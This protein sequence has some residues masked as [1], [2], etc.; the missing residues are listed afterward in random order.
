MMSGSVHG[1][2][3]STPPP[4]PPTWLSPVS[5]TDEAVSA[6]TSRVFKIEGYSETR[7]L[8]GAGNSIRFPTFFLGGHGWQIWYYPDGLHPSLSG[9]WIS[10]ALVLVGNGDS[11][12]RRSVRGSG[13]AE[14]G[15]PQQGQ[16]G[17]A[18]GAGRATLGKD[19]PLGVPEFVER[20]RLQNSCYLKGDCVSVRCDISVATTNVVARG[21]ELSELSE[22]WSSFVVV[23]PSDLRRDL[24]RLLSSGAGADVALEVRG[25]TIAAHWHILAAR[26]S[27]FAAEL[28]DGT[29]EEE[30][31]IPSSRVRIDAM[32][33]TA[34]K[35]MLHFIYTDSLPA[36]MDEAGGSIMPMAPDLLVAADRYDLWGL[37]SMCEEKLCD[38]IAVD[39]PVLG[40]EGFERL[41]ESCPSV[42]KDHLAVFAP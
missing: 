33:A 37:K 20:A 29:T 4:S 17:F 30:K 13:Q 2:D 21:T 31:T 14:T 36:T 12:P 38:H 23:P 11:R 1:N 40:T 9:R 32:D 8:L 41:V 25:E 16:G 7:G 34:F 22:P 19:E 15:K 24:G 28:L 5:V 42:L 35:A 18:G 3:G 26:S 39:T 6:S 10:M 27:V